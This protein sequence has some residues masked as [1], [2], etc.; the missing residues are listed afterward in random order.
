MPN[1]LA[2]LKKYGT[3]LLMLVLIIIIANMCKESA[4]LTYTRYRTSV[5]GVDSARVAKWEISKKALLEGVNIQLDSGFRTEILDGSGNWV[6]QISNL[7]EVAASVD[8]NSNIRIRL[9][10][11]SFKRDS[12]LTIGWNFLKDQSTPI[13]NPISFKI[14]AYKTNIN[15]LLKYQNNTTIISYDE[16]QNLST[17]EKTNYTQIIDNTQEKLSFFELTKD[18]TT[19]FT[20]DS[21]NVDSK[22]VYYYFIDI[23]FSDIIN[24]LTENK[25]EQFSNLGIN[26][27]NDLTFVIDWSV[28]N[29][30]SGEGTIDEDQYYKAYQVFQDEIPEGYTAYSTNSLFLID[31][32]N[33]YI[34]QS[35]D[36][37]FY[38]YTKYTSS[39]IGGEPGF[40]FSSDLGGDVRVKYS[41]LNDEQKT[42]ILGYQAPNSSS[43]LNDLKH[44]AEKLEYNQYTDYIKDNEEL[45]SALGY[46]SYGLKVKIQF[47]LNISQ[48]IP[49]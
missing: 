14:S 9:D 12:D 21:E 49:N 15:S 30:S 2:Y 5:D 6:F 22:I 40:N 31:G 1:I 24:T 19:I 20:L 13:D 32:V 3:I 16:Y 42:K 8:L 29:S 26:E 46:L 44:Y 33:Y 11:D 38:E 48:K 41:E 23:N 34:C 17:T 4:P 47:D 39:L 25:K 27:N 45:Q 35:N 43:T 10:N 36:M 28:T 37:N 7:S 18:T